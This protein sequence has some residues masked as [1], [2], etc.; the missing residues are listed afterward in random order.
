MKNFSPYKPEALLDY[1]G[2]RRTLTALALF[3]CLMVSS[4]PGRAE[5]GF[6]DSYR[7]S[8]EA[9]KGNKLFHE[10]KYERAR[11]GYI[12]A[13][14]IAGQKSGQD[15]RLLFNVGSTF[16]KEGDLD[17]AEKKF[18]EAL[19]ADDLKL[20]GEAHYN[21]GNVYF[22]KGLAAGEIEQLEKAVEHY[23][24]ALEVDPDDQDAKFNIEVVRRHI[25]L[26]KQEQK[27]GDTCPNPKPGDQKKDNKDQKKSDQ[28][29]QKGEKGQEQEK[30]ENQEKKED[31]E[32]QG[33]QEK[34]EPA[35]KPGDTATPEQV[36]PQGSNKAGE[37]MT[38][39][40]AQRFLQ[41]VQEREKEDLK[42]AIEAARQGRPGK[43][44]DW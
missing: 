12:K 32:K 36:K 31:Q 34:R 21:L 35:P 20:R 37:K 6:I 5:E 43:D 4:I 44:K 15:H 30:K 10:G 8:R 23:Q 11:A 17:Q 33:D 2:R 3:L 14:D 16:Y 41:A 13:G 7:M 27:K 26:K 1:I 40:E 24:K 25:N 42:K 18:G 28:K 29:N 9:D 38:E 22:Q 39:E 19:A